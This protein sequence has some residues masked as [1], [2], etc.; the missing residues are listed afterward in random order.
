M[1][2]KQNDNTSQSY[3]THAYIL[4]FTKKNQ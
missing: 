1:S 3:I 2:Q 4:L